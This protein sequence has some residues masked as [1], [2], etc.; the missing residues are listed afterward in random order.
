MPDVGLRR[1]SRG[2]SRG[3]EGKQRQ[4]AAQTTVKRE[5]W[6]FL[7]IWDSFRWRD[8]ST[9]SS[10]GGIRYSS[11]PQ[12]GPDHGSQIEFPWSVPVRQREVALD[13]LYLLRTNSPEVV[14]QDPTG[15]LTPQLGS[16]I[17]GV[18]EVQARIDTGTRY[19]RHRLT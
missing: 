4:D 1:R 10:L 2:R 5:R 13:L 11:A 8:M 9:A 6:C 3:E 19:V 12:T 16:V 18:A 14:P 15:D 17:H 7:F